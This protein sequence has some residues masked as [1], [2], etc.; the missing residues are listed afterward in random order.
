MSYYVDIGGVEIDKAISVSESGDR[1][2]TVYD[3]VGGKKFPVAQHENLKTWTIK[4]Q[5]ENEDIFDDLAD[6]LGDSGS[7]RM[8]I[9]GEGKKIS[10]RVLIQKYSKDE[11]ESAGVYAGSISLIEYDKAGVKTAS[12]PYVARAGSAP[13][14]SENIAVTADNQDTWTYD[15]EKIVS[16]L[17]EKN[18]NWKESALQRKYTN[19][20]GET[21]NPATVAIGETVKIT[22]EDGNSDFT[23]EQQKENYW[24]NKASST[25]AEL[26]AGA[27]ESLPSYGSE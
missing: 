15:A 21:V 27:Y 12:V 5:T 24:S 4:F 1:E 2:I 3:A 11:V 14:A 9:N 6:M 25:I 7:V 26:Y 17:N 22:V 20:S 10:K 18:P 23:T 19:K 16:R 8:V 13:K